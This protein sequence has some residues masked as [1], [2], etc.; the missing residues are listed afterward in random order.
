[1]IVSSPIGRILRIVLLILLLLGLAWWV[2][3]QAIVQLLEG[4]DWRWVLAAFVIVQ[5]Q[6]VLSA[7]RWQITAVRL[8]Q[9]LSVPRAISEYYLATV[10]NLSLPGGVSG[11]AA[12][13]YR[14]RRSS[15]VG[16]AAYGVMLE[17]L[18]GQITLLVLMLVG[19]LT[20]PLLMPGS[21]PDIGAKLLWTVAFIIVVAGAVIR[22]FTRFGR[23]GHRMR[24]LAQFL[25]GFRPAVRQAWLTDQQWRVQCVLSLLIVLSYVAVFACSALALNEPLPLSALISIVP[26]VLLSMT[27]PLSIG[28]WGIREAA[29]ASLWPLAALSAEAGVATSIVYGA[30]S[31]LA[32]LPGLGLLLARTPEHEIS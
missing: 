30:V 29:A 6:V 13:I 16:S 17:R 4:T 8:G 22:L 18:A 14:H 26:L 11:D 27:I 5:I 15:G 12:R 24:A 10:A 1:M 28:G 31:L 32:C 9:T 20:W 7:M 19:W 2:D 23:N 3:M 25:S 21:A